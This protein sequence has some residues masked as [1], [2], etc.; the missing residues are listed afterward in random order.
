MMDK[1]AFIN[2]VR[3]YQD[4]AERMRAVAASTAWQW[5]WFVP[6]DVGGL[7]ELMGGREA[8]IGKLDA[9][10]VADS[11]LE[12]ELCGVIPHSSLSTGFPALDNI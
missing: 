4:L 6:H 9:L 5:T 12:G 7:V 8:F 1:G 11:S 3:G 10:F 2:R